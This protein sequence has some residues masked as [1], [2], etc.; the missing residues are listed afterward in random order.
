MNKTLRNIKQRMGAIQFGL[1]RLRD[2]DEQVTTF[3]VKL[4][5]N[6]G[7]MLSCLVTDSVPRLGL[8]N[9]SV[10]LIQKYHNDYL[11][12]A[13][14][15]TDEMQSGKKILSVEIT[16]ACWFV[17]KSRGS[18]SWLQQKYVYEP[19]NVISTTRRGEAA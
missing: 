16:K 8:L 3:Q 1:L 9:K 6:E 15:V 14:K 17:K 18:V 19:A 11:Y 10:N 2:Q 5:E 13:G 7:A 4:A 12:I